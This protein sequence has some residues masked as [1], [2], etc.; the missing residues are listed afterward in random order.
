MLI[1]EGVSNVLP[2]ASWAT[3]KQMKN[4][5]GHARLIKRT[6]RSDTQPTNTVSASGSRKAAIQLNQLT[7]M[8]SST[9]TPLVCICCRK[10][11]QF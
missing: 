1:K 11:I 5:K 8:M 4:K 6:A 10:D 2:V 3:K 7:L 9:T